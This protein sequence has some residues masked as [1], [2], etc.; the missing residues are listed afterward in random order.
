MFGPMNHLFDLV[1]F[2]T[3]ENL[4]SIQVWMDLFDIY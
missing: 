4:K 2:K 3:H 1:Y